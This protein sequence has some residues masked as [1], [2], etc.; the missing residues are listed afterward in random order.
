MWALSLL[1]SQVMPNGGPSTANP[2]HRMGRAYS[3]GDSHLSVR[4]RKGAHV[5]RWVVVV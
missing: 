2:F 5:V 1:C 3:L 4:E